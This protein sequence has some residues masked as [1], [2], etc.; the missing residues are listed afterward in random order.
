MMNELSIYNRPFSS[1][2]VQQIYTL[3]EG[4]TT[5]TK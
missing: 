4:V 2:E 1:E 3:E 5:L